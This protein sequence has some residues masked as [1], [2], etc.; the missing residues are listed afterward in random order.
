MTAPSME[1]EAALLFV[2]ELPVRLRLDGTWWRITDTPTRIRESIWTAPLEAHMPL[3][4]WRFQITNE[5]QVS[6]MVDVCK[7]GDGWHVHRQYQ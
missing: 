5:Q 6:W 1:H 2:D 4:G 7:G 3:Y